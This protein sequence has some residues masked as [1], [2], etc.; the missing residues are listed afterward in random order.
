MLKTSSGSLCDPVEAQLISRHASRVPRLN[1][2]R[3]LTRHTPINQSSVSIAH[4]SH[5][6]I[7][8]PTLVRAHGLVCVL[9]MLGPRT[10]TTSLVI[11]Q[12]PDMYRPRILKKSTNFRKFCIYSL[13]CSRF[14]RGDP[15]SPAFTTHFTLVGVLNQ[16]HNLSVYHNRRCR[17]WA[18]H[19]KYPH[20]ATNQSC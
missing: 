2:K 11:K 4:T 18:D 19:P 12:I 7:I 15:P 13:F 8:S 5:Q 16:T 14:C 1:Q 3:I 9:P 20:R 17:R 10:M 6:Q